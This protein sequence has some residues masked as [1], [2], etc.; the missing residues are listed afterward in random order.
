MYY[1]G[2]IIYILYSTYIEHLE[3]SE[4]VSFSKGIRLP[5]NYQKTLF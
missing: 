1:G 5:S 2:K 3:K 4:V